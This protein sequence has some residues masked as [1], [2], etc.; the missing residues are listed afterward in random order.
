MQSREQNLAERLFLKDY[1]EI[2]IYYETLILNTLY[3]K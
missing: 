3:I 1:Y 2:Y